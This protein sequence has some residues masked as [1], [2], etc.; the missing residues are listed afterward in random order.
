M[1]ED[2][3]G[4]WSMALSSRTPSPIFDRSLYRLQTEW[5]APETIQLRRGYRDCSIVARRHEKEDQILRLFGR[6]IGKEEMVSLQA[7]WIV[8][9]Q[10]ALLSSEAREPF[11]VFPA[12]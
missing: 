8:C 7:D 4:T 5:A 6:T 2:L 9:L 12:V 1:I 11:R 3:P 10:S